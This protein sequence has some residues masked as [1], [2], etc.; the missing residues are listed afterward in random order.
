MLGRLEHLDATSVT[1]KTLHRLRRVIE[2]A[3][4]SFS[5]QHFSSLQETNP[6]ASS[7]GPLCEYVL[8]AF[9][10]AQLWYEE[11]WRKLG[12]TE[13]GGS[14]NSSSSS[15]SANGGKIAAGG[16]VPNASLF[17]TG[18]MSS[19][20]DS[21]MRASAKEAMREQRE[22][23]EAKK[24]AKQMQLKADEECREAVEAEE[25]ASVALQEAKH[26]KEEA[27]RETLSAEKELADVRA[28]RAKIEKE[29]GND[30]LL[31][32]LLREQQEAMDAQES[33]KQKRKHAESLELSAQQTLKRAKKEKA[34]A[35]RASTKALKY[36]RKAQKEEKEALDARKKTQE[37]MQ[38]VQSQ[39]KERDR[40][41]Q[42]RKG[43]VEIG[44]VEEEVEKKKQETKKQ[45]DKEQREQRRAEH[46][47]MRHEHGNS[48]A[49]PTTLTTEH[50]GAELHHHMP[51]Q[52]NLTNNNN[53]GRGVLKQK[54][55]NNNNNKEVNT[56]STAAIKKEDDAFDKKKKENEKKVL[57]SMLPPG[58]PPIS[59]L[60]KHNEQQ[61]A[62]H[63]NTN[64]FNTERSK[65]NNTS[66]LA[67]SSTSAPQKTT[68][69][70]KANVQDRQSKLEERRRRSR[71]KRERE[72]EKGQQV[73][74]ASFREDV[75]QLDNSLTS[76][77]DALDANH[78]GQ[79]TKVEVMRGLTQQN[80]IVITILS[81]T[82]ALSPLR[83][84]RAWAGAFRAMDTNRDGHVDL[85]ELR[86]FVVGMYSME[87][88][89]DASTRTRLAEDGESN[90]VVNERLTNERS[91]IL[92]YDTNIHNNNEQDT[93]SHKMSF[94]AAVS[95]IFSA[96][97]KTTTANKAALSLRNEDVSLDKALLVARLTGDDI[98]RDVI[99][100]TPQLHVLL[101]PTTFRD[102]L[103]MLKTKKEDV[104]NIRE[105]TQFCAGLLAGHR[106][107]VQS[108]KDNKKIQD[109]IND[110]MDS[111]YQLLD[112][113]DGKSMVG[114]RFSRV[115][116]VPFLA[117]LRAA[118][119][120][121]NGA[122][123]QKRCP[124]VYKFVHLNGTLEGLHRLLGGQFWLSKRAIEI[125]C[126]G[127]HGQF[128][129]KE[130]GAAAAANVAANTAANTA[131]NTA[132]VLVKK[133]DMTLIN[134]VDE[135]F[136]SAESEFQIGRGGLSTVKKMDIMKSL[137]VEKNRK[138]MN[139]CPEM[140]PMLNTSMYWSSLQAMKTEERGKLNQFEMVC[141]CYGM[142]CYF[143]HSVE[144]EKVTKISKL[145]SISKMGMGNEQ[146]SHQ[147]ATIGEEHTLIV[148]SL[149]PS[150]ILK[151]A[152]EKYESVL[153]KGGQVPTSN[154][155]AV[156]AKVM[157]LKEESL[158]NS[159]STSIGYL[160]QELCEIQRD[161]DGRPLHQTKKNKMRQV[162]KD[163][164]LP[165]DLCNILLPYVP[166]CYGTHQHL[167]RR[168]VVLS[169]VCCEYQKPCV[170]DIRLSNTEE[171]QL[172]GYR[173]YSTSDIKYTI[174]EIYGTHSAI[175]GKPTLVDK[176]MS[177]Y[178]PSDTELGLGV[179]RKPIVKLVAL[180]EVLIKIACHEKSIVLGSGVSILLTYDGEDRAMNGNVWLIDFDGFEVQDR[181]RTNTKNTDSESSNEIMLQNL[182]EVIVALRFVGANLRQRAL[183]NLRSRIGS[184]SEAYA[185]CVLFE[186]L[187]Q[188]RNGTVTC[189]RL[190]KRFATDSISRDAMKLISNRFFPQKGTMFG[191]KSLR[192][193]FEKIVRF[194]EGRKTLQVGATTE[195]DVQ[196]TRVQSFDQIGLQEYLFG[197]SGK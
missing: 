147:I 18:S 73:H 41:L 122:Q 131:T 126:I 176:L 136:G 178:A 59:N 150:N 154:L 19:L 90:A 94:D 170:C 31:R 60:L 2:H 12:L 49:L 146:Y 189:A 166:K 132:A 10:M 50:D 161:N 106:R 186:L 43:A 25:K 153:V 182:D 197:R 78:D 26:A 84:P 172:V 3:G 194:A 36:E 159:I 64:A 27:E 196:A 72:E 180:R 83:H 97:S 81:S 39:K 124:M 165:N 164:S 113:P 114:R 23:E 111:L 56:N 47:R 8:T 123:V 92:A 185:C 143:L 71:T 14:G 128:L 55:V 34:E 130:S 62:N 118:L 1:E 188:E 88:E 192:K 105:F 68:A 30:I 148:P 107:L 145:S 42:E 77:F 40:V 144:E 45:H 82:S 29:G 135:L 4:P 133:D 66:M 169:D 13:E 102:G 134:A 7:F 157:S 191:P 120:K 22:A 129:H 127:Y 33:A 158:Y 65:N 48:A 193:T 100:G 112:M 53:Q 119:V 57:S 75:S 24:K 187:D 46:E 137:S 5:L 58:L 163:E 174:H 87:K 38:Q 95:S 103:R 121:E 149:V 96:V 98:V 70:I 11:K 116:S 80:D 85:D 190:C 139:K 109:R 51:D 168:Y 151:A 115:R 125:A 141:Y 167:G 152:Q 171:P 195:I 37:A 86:S 74:V 9:D 79:L 177:F 99:R 32:S 89:G 104:V 69:P 160:Q 91:S 21:K 184:C 16:G 63:L 93:Q 138:E 54:Q 67:L 17:D 175:A 183:N 117:Q 6:T 20:G 155:S 101:E 179:V 52:P 110:Q 61:H 181:N 15:S 140:I 108:V 44:L 173:H 162:K 142:Y 156:V 35:T 28:V 76:L